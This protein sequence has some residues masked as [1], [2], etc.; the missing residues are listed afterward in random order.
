MC[1]D[2]PERPETDPQFIYK[3]ITVLETWSY[4]SDPEIRQ[5]SPQ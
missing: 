1:Q 5:Y 2:L 3:I 4:M